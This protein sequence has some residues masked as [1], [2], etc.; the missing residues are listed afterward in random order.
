MTDPHTTAG[1][2]TEV[3]LP[4]QVEEIARNIRS[5]PTS[6]TLFRHI[7]DLQDA[8]AK[9]REVS[10]NLRS[11]ETEEREAIYSL[12]P[13][14]VDVLEDELRRSEIHTSFADEILLGTFSGAIQRDAAEA[15]N[16]L[17][18]PEL[19][20]YYDSPDHSLVRLVR[21]LTQ[22]A[23]ESGSDPVSRFC[24]SSLGQLCRHR[25]STVA[26]VVSDYEY[27]HE[28]VEMAAGQIT[29]YQSEFNNFFWKRCRL[30]A[31]VSVHQPETVC[32]TPSL[33]R[34]LRTACE[35]KDL[36]C[37][38]FVGLT[39]E[40]IGLEI[41]EESILK[42]HAKLRTVDALIQGFTS[43]SITDRVILDIALGEAV[44]LTD[45]R[46]YTTEYDWIVERIKKAP[47]STER[48][49]F[50]RTLGEIV[51][52]QESEL[53]SLMQSLID[54]AKDPNPFNTE[55]RILGEVVTAMQP[56]SQGTGHSNLIS[57]LQ[58]QSHVDRETAA[59][60]VGQSVVEAG[61]RY[62]DI[63][64]EKVVGEIKK[65]DDRNHLIESLLQSIVVSA[66]D[67]GGG[68]SHINTS[69]V[70]DFEHNGKTCTLPAGVVSDIATASNGPVREAIFNDICE[71]VSTSNGVIRCAI[72]RWIGKIVIET[73]DDVLD[74][75]P[76]DL[77]DEAK[78]F[79]PSKKLYRGAIL[80]AIQHG[81]ANKDVDPD[82]DLQNDLHKASWA[83]DPVYEVLGE[84]VSMKYQER[85]SEIPE[86]LVD[87][88]LESEASERETNA[89]VLGEVLAATASGNLAP[90]L[91]KVTNILQTSTGIE[92]ET[93]A[94]VLGD[95]YATE[96]SMVDVLQKLISELRSRPV[97][98]DHVVNLLTTLVANEE[99][100][101][102]ELRRAI[103]QTQDDHSSE[104]DID[105]LLSERDP[106]R[107]CVLSCL[108]RKIAA[109]KRTDFPNIQRQ[110]QESLANENDLPA[111]I[112]MVSMDL[113]ISIG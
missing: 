26:M 73:E 109:S 68:E 71:D 72:A 111:E 14:L 87:R 36:R 89:Q 82:S 93:I 99:V 76:R 24:V 29:S 45:Y 107:R 95:V 48:G 56:P 67:A 53:D 106:G 92:R 47:G 51:L 38:T 81:T 2:D 60:A 88:I 12:C 33:K 63:E 23:Y 28:I 75:I 7:L 46:G 35:I 30:I 5:G 59:R 113:L 103:V 96:G 3:R 10:D 84:V 85:K 11:T 32:Q 22:V 42:P 37:A 57:S 104:I 52:I 108:Q 21:V 40:E 83:R 49:T 55:V 4:D 58:E 78:N 86:Y 8:C 54:R 34:G 94:K 50:V 69:L 16:N 1:D 6:N 20:A 91:Q 102:E 61:G 64:P 80:G 98:H 65:H 39:C 17:V 62:H 90:E 31:T 13:D 110:V 15:I 25:P 66:E 77:A 101:V 18:G 27:S 44:F 9:A 79:D 112:R 19:V 100:Q 105:S 97:V 74:G 41:S 70:I 43:G